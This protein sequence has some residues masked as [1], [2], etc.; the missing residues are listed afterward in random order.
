MRI[1]ILKRCTLR[2]YSNGAFWAVLQCSRVFFSCQ[3]KCH[4]TSLHIT[5]ALPDDST[6]F[7]P[8][9]NVFILFLVNQLNDADYNTKTVH[10]E[11]LLKWCVLSCS[12]MLK[13]LLLLSAKMSLHITSHYFCTARW[14]NIIQTKDQHVHPLPCFFTSFLFFVFLRYTLKSSPSIFNNHFMLKLPKIT[15]R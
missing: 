15:G 12:P 11:E 3:L 5:S 8:R 9:T 1:T 7:K 4:F 10:F 6:L 2:S 13:S 14:F